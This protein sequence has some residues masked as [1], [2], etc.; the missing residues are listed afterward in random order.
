MKQTYVPIWTFS[1]KYEKRRVKAAARQ[2]RV[3]QYFNKQV[4]AKIFKEGDLV[5]KN[6]RASRSI[7][8]QRKLS[9]TWEGPYLVFSVIGNEA[10]KLQIIEDKEILNAWNARYLR[11]YYC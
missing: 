5:L 9:L 10:Y 6:C 8:E 4:K 11:I 1:K 2:K 7:G 3:V